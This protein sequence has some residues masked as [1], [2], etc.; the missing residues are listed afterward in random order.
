MIGI[1]T[2]AFGA[3]LRAGGSNVVIT[4][5][6]AE[7]LARA[8]GAPSDLEGEWA[9]WSHPTVDIVTEPEPA[10]Y[11]VPLAAQEPA[12]YPDPPVVKEPTPEPEPLGVVPEPS[13]RR[14]VQPKKAAKKAPAKKAG[15]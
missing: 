14:K 3:T 12:G 7:A 11:P 13:P 10:E 15:K 9:W 2:H 4:H 8:L 6:T 1:R 5:D